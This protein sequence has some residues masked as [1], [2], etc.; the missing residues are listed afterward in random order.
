MARYILTQ[1]MVGQ[2]TNGTYGKYGRGST[3]ADTAGNAVAGDW[4]WPALCAAPNA[5][6]LQPLDS[7]AS[8]AMGLPITTAQA[9]VLVGHGGCGTDAGN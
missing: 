3:I 4:I 2:P 5:A 6:Q 7:A 9:Q 8:T 1:T